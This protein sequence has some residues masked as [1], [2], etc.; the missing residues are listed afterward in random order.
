MS[1][2]SDT[3]ERLILDWIVFNESKNLQTPSYF[4]F[5]KRLARSVSGKVR[6]GLLAALNEDLAKEAILKF[7][8]L[9]YDDLMNKR[10]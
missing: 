10:I 2:L 4:E 1:D 9:V 7:A 3:E 5:C 6:A 8:P